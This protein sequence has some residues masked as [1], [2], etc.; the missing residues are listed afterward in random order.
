MK[1]IQIVFTFFLLFIANQTVISQ[2]KINQLDANGKRTGIWKKQYSNNK[3]RYQGQ[4]EAGKE[5]GIF[6]FYSALSSQHPIA[7]KTFT[8]NT[9]IATVEFYTEKG[10]LQSKGKMKGKKHIGKWLYYHPNEKTILSEENY[11][12]GILNGISKTY[13]K[14]GK[15]TEILFYKNGKLHGNT[16]RYASNGILLDDL[17]YKNGKLHGLAKYYNVKGKLIYTGNY[18]DDKKVGKWEYF[19]NG[20]T[21]NSN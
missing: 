5:I 11:T 2:E 12:N 3:I 20:K 16:K 19:E 4:F 1:K 14:T 10:I 18:E 13:Y 7:I 21:I 17:N 8:K 6:K 15:I 9:E